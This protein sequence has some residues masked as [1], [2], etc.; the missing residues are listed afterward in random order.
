MFDDHGF[1]DQPERCVLCGTYV[2]ILFDGVTHGT[3]LGCVPNVRDDRFAVL[4]LGEGGSV[5]MPILCWPCRGRV[6]DR[7]PRFGRS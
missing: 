7:M 4:G 1:F 3:P 2:E 5:I 6:L